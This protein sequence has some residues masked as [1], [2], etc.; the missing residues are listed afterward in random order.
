MES[1]MDI[2]TYLPAKIQNYYIVAAL[3][4]NYHIILQAWMYMIKIVSKSLRCK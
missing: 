4:N 2:Y 1:G 3:Q